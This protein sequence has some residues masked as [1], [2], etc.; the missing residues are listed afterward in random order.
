MTDNEIVKLYFDRDEKA[1]DETEKKYGAYCRK[2]T[3]GIVGKIEDAEECLNDTRLK[4]WESIPPAKPDNLKCYLGKISRNN[5]L[6]YLR[7]QKAVKRGGD[8]YTQSV[9]ELSECISSSTSPEKQV[10]D[11]FIVD[12]INSFIDSLEREK[13]VIFVKRYW[14]MKQT[15]DISKEM[16]I[17]ESKVKTTLFRLR[18]QLKAYLEQ[19][20]IEI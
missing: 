7:S 6:N 14:Y 9:D 15:A 11:K 2:I 1:L 12:V 18:K 3:L 10:E 20:G 19:E 13:R 8:V 16:G 17:S 5:A 4:V